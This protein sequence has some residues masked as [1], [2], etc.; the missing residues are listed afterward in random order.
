[1]E[2]M[3][4]HNDKYDVVFVSEGA[5]GWLPDLKK[6]GKTIR[7]LL[8]DDGFFYI[9]DSHPIYLMFDEEELSKNIT[10]IKYPY[11]KKS[12]D[13][14]NSIGGYASDTKHGVET[15]FWMY[16]TSDVINELISA[17]MHIEFFNEFQG[18][19]WDAGG[20]TRVESGL[21]N[22]DFNNGLFPMSFSLKAVPYNA[23]TS[24]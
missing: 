5:I 14:D 11:F 15:Y 18:N 21:Y 16:K 4:A 3:E 20:C 23:F 1:M 22:Y 6:W 19:Y 7:H 13:I 24:H 17:G 10:K 9:F 2:F 12:P 8:K